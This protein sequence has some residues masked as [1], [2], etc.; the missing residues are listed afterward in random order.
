MNTNESQQPGQTDE[1]GAE[2]IHRDPPDTTLTEGGD[3]DD[4]TDDLSDI[5]T[6]T[7]PDED[8]ESA[9]DDSEVDPD[10]AD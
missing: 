6:G 10:L 3:S 9:D 4:E 8:D 2:A 5:G 7:E 1:E